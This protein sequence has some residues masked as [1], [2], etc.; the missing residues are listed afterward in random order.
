MFSGQILDY[1]RPLWP[2]PCQII[3]LYGQILSL[4][5]SLPK[6]FRNGLAVSYVLRPGAIPGGLAWMFFIEFGYG[7]PI[8]RFCFEFLSLLRI[9]TLQSLM[10]SFT[11]HSLKRLRSKALHC[12]QETENH[13]CAS[14]FY[15]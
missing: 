6:G 7:I 8:I 15:L 1:V 13:E 12:N 2:L 3:V 10:I 4:V 5:R 9:V 11:N 14:P